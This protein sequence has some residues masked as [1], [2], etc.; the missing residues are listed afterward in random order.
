MLFFGTHLRENGSIQQHHHNF[1]VPSGPNETEAYQTGRALKKLKL[2]SHFLRKHVACTI[3]YVKW[4]AE[5]NVGELLC[6]HK[7]VPPFLPPCR[8]VSVHIVVY[9]E[10]ALIL[11][12]ARGLV[13]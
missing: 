6:T 1:F 2:K 4:R 13:I 11:R 12:C 8:R 3:Y 5:T 9:G 10:R 7:D